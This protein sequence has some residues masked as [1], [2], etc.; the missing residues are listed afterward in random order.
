MAKQNL[1]RSS[2][3]ESTISR[4]ARNAFLTTVI[5]VFAA[6]ANFFASLRISLATGHWASFGG[7]AV[8]FIF[9]II[10]VFSAMLVR[11]G[12]KE[13]GIWLL[14]ISFVIVSAIRNA[15]NEGLGASFGLLAAT[16]IPAVG[17]LTLRPKF[18]NRTLALGIISGAFYL[19]FDIFIS[20]YLPPYRQ[21]LENTASMARM[22]TFFVTVIT[23]GYIFMLIRQ[24]RFL[25]LSSKLTL[26]MVLIVIGPLIA[27]SFAGAISLE[28]T[29]A[30]RQN[31]VMQSKALFLAQHI[32]DFIHSNKNLLQAEA[33]TPAL[34]E[35][36]INKGENSAG[37]EDLA[38]LRELAIENLR[39]FRR[40]D[41]LAIKSYAIL[42]ASGKN[43]LDTT[44]NNIG[45]NEAETDYFTHAF[46][47]NL[48]YISNIVRSQLSNEYSFYI[49]APINAKNGERLGVLRVEYNTEAL[50]THVSEFASAESAGDKEVF[51]ALLVTIPVE[52]IAPEDPSS[53]F[54]ILANAKDPDLNFMSATP[55]TANVFTSLQMSH[56]FPVGSTFHF[57]ADIPGLDQ[58]LRNRATAPVFEAQAFPRPT[59]TVRPLDIVASA[60]IEAERTLQWFVIVSQD[61]RSY[62]APFQQQSETSILITVLISIGAAIL[63]YSGSRYLIQPIINLTTVAEEI[64]RGDLSTRAH[65]KTEDEIG[66]LGKAFNSMTHQL[67]SS[68]TTLE[69]RV[70]DRTQD[71]ERQ[72]QQLR[73]AVDVGKIAVS[74]RNLD[75]LLIQ[76]TE[77]IS[78]RFGFYHVGI[79]LLDEQKE[80]AVLRAA[81]STGGARMLARNHKLQVGQVGIVGY[82]TNTGK[83]RI[84]LDVGQDAAYFD[85]PDLP[86]T[87]SEMALALIAGGEILGALDIQSTAEK[88]FTEAD[89]ATLQVL[90][91]Q[92]AVSI[93]NARL[94][95]QNQNALQAIRRAY[96]E[97]SHLGWDELAFRKKSYGYKNKSDGIVLPLGEGTDAQ[98]EQVITKDK[99]ILDEKKLVAN[100]PISVR[101]KPIGAMR[102]SKPD[103]AQPWKENELELA[104]TIAA[105]LSGAMDS[106]RLFDE[107]RKQA[108]RERIV[109][110]ITT[111]MRET[112]SVDAVMQTAADEI[113]KL[114]ELEHIAIRFTPEDGSKAQKEEEV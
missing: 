54:L 71:L 85:N 65:I 46:Q 113:Y 36:L 60:E 16:L 73:A 63:A 104:K 26:A 14:L 109:G 95:E 8:V 3:E 32:N 56:V 33:Q 107:T 41:I 47:E 25:L 70:A 21:T 34:I 111:R 89:I 11:K 87:R 108:E 110:E 69:D 76:A 106:A 84:A 7:T 78:Q 20:R 44:L 38:R 103:S 93:E 74:L 42:D 48:P 59:T 22:I 17:L 77:L 68:I 67:Q 101:G 88:A 9:V 23:I 66:T 18:F 98:F 75:S 13:R 39:S 27:L 2:S 10:S 99:I 57:T 50:E 12:Q 92:I 83:A 51:A 29:L 49:S 19:I 1:N 80:Y 5:F 94:F 55:L 96:G 40:K 97:Q 53:V 114:L 61:L 35:Y 90:A 6:V 58:G 4:Q 45:L 82:V 91:D 28:N 112:M 52:Q 62:N 102:L 15:L 30:P 81:N 79:F 31:E 72:A 105:E 43:I 100:I 64:A 37:S 24:N 86:Q